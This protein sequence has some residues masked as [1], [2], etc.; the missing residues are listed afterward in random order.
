MVHTLKLVHCVSSLCR[1]SVDDAFDYLSNPLRLGEWAL[2]CWATVEH[3]KGIAHGTSLFDGTATFARTV[4]D[5]ERLTVDFEVG[6]HPERLQRRIC[7]H[8]IR[9]DSIGAQPDSSLVMLVAWRTAAMDDQRWHRLIAAHEA[10][11]LILR[12]RLQTLTSDER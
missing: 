7:S 8:I 4:A 9:G 5:R 6:D 1:V 3:S 10:E 2:G 11:I 12:H